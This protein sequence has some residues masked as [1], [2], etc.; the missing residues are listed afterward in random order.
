MENDRQGQCLS[1]ATVTWQTVAGGDKLE[2]KI[3]IWSL[4][5]VKET[6]GGGGG[7]GLRSEGEGCHRMVLDEGFQQLTEHQQ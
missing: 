7:G 6:Q 5:K 4:V 1:S 2:E 3:T